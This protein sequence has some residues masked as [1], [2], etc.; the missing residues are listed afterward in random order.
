V[1]LHDYI[2]DQEGFD[3]ANL[4]SEWSWLL[5]EVLTPWIVN[6]LG[7]I[8]LVRE[9]GTVSF[10]DVGGG[11]VEQIANSREDFITK[12][13][14]SNNAN[15]WLAIPLVDGLVKAGLSLRQQTVYGFKIPPL[16][17]GKYELENFEVTDISVHYGFLGDLYG[18]M[19]DVPDGARVRVK[20]T[21]KPDVR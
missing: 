13:D 15:D 20:I 10:F 9:D 1:D 21:N 6:Q 8:V 5:P 4:L 19:K 7:D 16:L 11:R 3:W 12:I 14:V 17:G 18:Q 2:I